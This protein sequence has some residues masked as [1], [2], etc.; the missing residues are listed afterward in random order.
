MRAIFQLQHSFDQVHP[1]SILGWLHN[2]EV[3][4]ISFLPSPMGNRLGPQ[5]DD[6]LVV[7]DYEI[8]PLENAELPYI[9]NEFWWRLMR[10]QPRRVIV[11][12]TPTE[13]FPHFTVVDVENPHLVFA[14]MEDELRPV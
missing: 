10:N 14:A 1:E 9:G 7:F 2:K 8:I 13:D 3:E 12:E 6:D 5:I 4:V 11:K